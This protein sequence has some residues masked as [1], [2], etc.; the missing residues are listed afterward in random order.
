ME[1]I[2]RRNNLAENM[3]ICAILI[4]DMLKESLSD[5]SNAKVHERRPS[6]Q[7]DIGIFSKL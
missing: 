3:L 4:F 6:L 5:M 7:R 2:D 1:E